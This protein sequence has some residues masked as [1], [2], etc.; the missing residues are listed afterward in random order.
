MLSET[1]LLLER[2][3]FEEMGKRI[4]PIEFQVYAVISATL[5]VCSFYVSEAMSL[6]PTLSQTESQVS[7][8]YESIDD[9]L[10]VDFN[11]SFEQHGS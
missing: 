9:T 1:A 2:R 8:N 5:L 3:S 7:K 6:T 10:K 4:Y 11:C